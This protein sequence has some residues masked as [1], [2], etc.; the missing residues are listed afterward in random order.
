MSNK[1]KK[2][3]KT[4][5]NY[6]KKK[7]KKCNLSFEECETMLL[8]Q[9]VDKI[10]TEQGRALM[11]QPQVKK[12]INIL[13][14]F[15][16]K[17]KRI[18]YGGTAINNLLPKKEQFYDITIE[19]PDYD[20]YSPSPIEDAKQLADKFANAGYSNVEA[21]SGIHVGTY[22]V[23]VDFIPIADITELPKSVYSRL[24]RESIVKSGI[25]YAPPNFLRMSMYL[26]LSRPQGAVQ[27]WEKV[28]NRLKL[29]NKHYPLL[30]KDEK[31]TT[32]NGKIRNDIKIQRNE[33]KLTQRQQEQVYKM[34]KDFFIDRECVFFGAYAHQLYSR[35]MPSNLRRKNKHIP[36]FDI[37]SENIEN[38]TN[39]LVISLASLEL[40]END[41]LL[42]VKVIRKPNIGELLPEHNEVL[43][44]D[45]V[46]CYIYKPLACH[47]YNE[48]TLN[49]RKVRIATID[50]MLSFYL[51]F[52]YLNRNG[53]DDKRILCMSDFLFRVQEKNKL[54]QQ[55]VLRR[56]TMSCYG[57]QQSL[58][59]IKEQRANKFRDI[60]RLLR[61]NK[62]VPD[63]YERWFLKYIPTDTAVRNK[64]ISLKK[65]KENISKQLLDTTDKANN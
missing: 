21:K 42:D 22:K 46:V 32:K 45:E 40:R 43:I 16:K 15:L 61:K 63:D 8:N 39:N 48:I 35:Y 53:Y 34:T 54:S 3:K 25:Y 14:S 20:F 47:S 41:K 56:F 29:L 5:K 38:D 6:T 4:N 33:G 28:Y 19:L 52:Y 2:N 13:E 26:E 17:T 60:K 30:P 18:C 50:T 49:D 55:G 58:R 24:K 23:F 37:L 12:I 27:R 65:I 59:D 57:T 11:N 31:C 10:E 62:P 64:K 9:V 36:D 51:A 44:G 1:T 7:P